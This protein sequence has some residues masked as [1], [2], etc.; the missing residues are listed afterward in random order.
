MSLPIVASIDVFLGTAIALTRNNVVTIEDNYSAYCK[1]MFR[2]LNSVV[3]DLGPLVACCEF[4]T[5]FGHQMEIVKLRV[6]LLAGFSCTSAKP[7]SNAILD[8]VVHLPGPR[9]SQ[10][11]TG[12]CL[13][14]STRTYQIQRGRDVISIRSSLSPWRLM[15]KGQS[16]WQFA[17][18]SFRRLYQRPIV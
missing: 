10:T 6:P 12:L 2:E 14:C 15:S 18:V 7:I 9:F 1:P 3:P 5:R 13:L 16:Y 8:C 11:P 4:K 17:A